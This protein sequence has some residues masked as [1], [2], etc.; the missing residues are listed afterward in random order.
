MR[1][2]VTTTKGQH[3]STQGTIVVGHRGRGGF[4]SAVLGS[5]GL[6]C[7]LHAPVPATVVRPE[8]QPAAGGHGRAGTR[9]TA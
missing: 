6:Q 2:G 7:G 8:Q 1:L 5:V 3:M 4:R 9:T